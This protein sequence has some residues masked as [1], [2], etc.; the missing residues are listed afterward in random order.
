[1]LEKHNATAADAGEVIRQ[2]GNLLYSICLMTLCN[3]QDAEDA[4][5]EAFLRYLLKTPTFR[6]AEHQKAW[7][8]R[9]AVNVSRDIGR[10]RTRHPALDWNTLDLGV[11]DGAPARAEALEGLAS[12]PYPYRIVLLLYYAAGYSTQEIAQI[13]RVGVSCVKKRLQRGRG[14]LKLQYE[15]E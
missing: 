15:T 5:Q 13:L 11:A 1:M 8:V 2:Y 10:S 6:D 7:L 4:V 14:L 3:R 12:L 9:V